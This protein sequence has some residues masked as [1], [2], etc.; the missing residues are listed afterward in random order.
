MNA[1]PPW[2]RHRPEIGRRWW[3]IVVAVPFVVATGLA[4]W[5]L[6]RE[7]SPVPAPVGPGTF[8]YATS[9][10]EEIDILGGA[11]HTYP[12]TTGLTI[13]R[14]RCGR[15]L[16]WR[17]LRDRSTAYELC[18]GRLRSIREVHQF[19]GQRDRRTYRCTASSSL[20]RGWRC[21]FEDTTEVARGGVVGA[22]R[23]DGV[24]TVHVRLTTRITGATDGTGTR[25]FWLRRTDGFPVRLAATN[26]NSTP[27]IVG[28]VDYRESYELRLRQRPGP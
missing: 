3:W 20:R 26:E 18:G 1:P 17:P 4:G 24:D 21:T 9:G 5:L 19:F 11:R 8:A 16:V 23:V 28:L 22:P 25:D 7:D 12:A 15:R 27:S 13:E 2:H 6:L 14:S 10:F